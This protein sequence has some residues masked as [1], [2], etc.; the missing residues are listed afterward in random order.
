M[1][2]V[3]EVPIK[4]GYRGPLRPLTA[5][6]LA[7]EAKKGSRL[8]ILFTALFL[9]TAAYYTIGGRLWK[10]LLK[11]LGNL[12]C[13]CFQS[14][15]RCY[16]TLSP[17]PS[18]SPTGKKDGLEGH[19]LEDDARIKEI[20]DSSSHSIFKNIALMTSFVVLAGGG[21]GGGRGG[22]RGGMGRGRGRGGRDMSLI[23]KT[24]RISQGPYKGKYLRLLKS[25][26]VLLF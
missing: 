17:P 16:K 25:V 14:F 4:T 13:N 24:V 23:S 1:R 7:C 8:W 19:Y 2:V 18:P 15:Q 21:G 9:G 22:H 10:N 5:V 3:L 26:N 12:L 6:F 11:V 20:L